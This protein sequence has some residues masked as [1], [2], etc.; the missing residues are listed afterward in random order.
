MAI[1]NG[2]KPTPDYAMREG[3]T[4]GI[5]SYPSNLDDPV[6][7]WKETLTPDTLYGGSPEGFS[8]RVD[9]LYPEVHEKMTNPQKIKTLGGVAIEAVVVGDLSGEVI[10]PVFYG[11]GG[12]TRASGAISEATELVALNPG[13]VYAFFNTP[14]YG[15]ADKMPKSV[16]KNLTKGDWLPLGEL[17]APAVEMLSEGRSVVVAGHSK[18]ASVAAAVTAHLNKAEALTLV[19]PLGHTPKSLIEFIKQW[20]K[21]ERHAARYKGAGFD[22][23]DQLSLP[24]E[25]L[26]ESEVNMAYDLSGKLAELR[27]LKKPTLHE[28]LSSAASQVEQ[29]IGV[30]TPELSEYGDLGAVSAIL[31]DIAMHNSGLSVEQISV[32]SQTHRSMDV[33]PVLSAY[34]ESAGRANG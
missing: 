12:E 22:K 10:T 34:Y 1:M 7:N 11:W 2:K 17:V 33:T 21:E 30:V 9:A 15:G 32:M 3:I 19:D 8:R 24:A 14:G 20:Y 29:K 13:G 25:G 4:V 16:R 23:K 6:V 27:A 26:T 31:G 18:G 28:L 5:R